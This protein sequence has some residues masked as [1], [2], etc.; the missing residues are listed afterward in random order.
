MRIHRNIYSIDGRVRQA[1]LGE[2]GKSWVPEFSLAP[3]LD[4][5]VSDFCI[6]PEQVKTVKDL[7]SKTIE[8]ESVE[9]YANDHDGYDILVKK[10]GSH[11]LTL[12]GV[13]E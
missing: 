8:A 2:G 6:T 10:K 4:I 9:L 3:T 11:L 13:M 12:F 1:T 7:V 5:E